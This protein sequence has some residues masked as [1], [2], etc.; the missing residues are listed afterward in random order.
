MASAKR[1]SG[2]GAELERSSSKD[3]CTDGDAKTE[4]QLAAS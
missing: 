3:G 1:W 2:A 4:L